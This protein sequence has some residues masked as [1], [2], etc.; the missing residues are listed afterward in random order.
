MA[1]E[2]VS[3]CLVAF[4]VLAGLAIAAKLLWDLAI[5][6]FSIVS[7]WAWLYLGMI[8]HESPIKLFHRVRFSAPPEEGTSGRILFLYEFFGFGS[9]LAPAA[10]I[11]MLATA[12]HQEGLTMAAQWFSQFGLVAWTAAVSIA[13]HGGMSIWY[14]SRMPEEYDHIKSLRAS[15][16]PEIVKKLIAKD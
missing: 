5:R 8:F 13:I 9:L 15:S 4:G 2:I 12:Q 1:T 7:L 6:P 3:W 16:I 14:G 11:S 10:V